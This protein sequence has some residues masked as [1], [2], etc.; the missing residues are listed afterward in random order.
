MIN[1]E[2]PLVKV[3]AVIGILATGLVLISSFL[4]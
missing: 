2:K 3:M 1:I 4:L